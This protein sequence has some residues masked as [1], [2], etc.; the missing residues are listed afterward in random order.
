M[1]IKSSISYFLRVVLVFILFG[2]FF[3]AGATVMAGKIPVGE[4]EP[5]L[6]SDGTGLIIM[7]AV[8]TATLVALILTS[9]WGGWKLAILLSLAY[10]GAVTV[11]MQIETW[12]FLSGLTVNS[13]ILA[14][15]FIMRLPVS[16]IVIPLAVWILGKGKAPAELAPN[17]ALVMPLR[18]WLWKLAVIAV[19]YVVLYLSAGYFIAWQNPEVRVFYTGSAYLPTFWE[20]IPK[21]LRDYPTLFPFQV[22]RAMLWT[23]CAL[24]IIR[25]SKVNVWWTALLVGIMFSLPQNVGHI[26]ANPLMPIASVRLSH[27]I[28]TTSSTFIFGLIVVWLLH[29][30]HESLFDLFGLKE[31]QKERVAHYPA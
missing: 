1:T 9:R 2:I 20:Q 12:Y 21:N 13:N 5:G 11:L 16:F 29:R 6:V 22:F 10:Y 8:E 18:Q 23:L 25:G 19:S 17:S 7:V 3:V 27:L 14:A 15:L 28:E 26:I 31:A 24:P 4:S 30:K